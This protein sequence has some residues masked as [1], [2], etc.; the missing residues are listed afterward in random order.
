MYEKY[1]MYI[2]P[3]LNSFPVD[4]SDFLKLPWEKID[5]PSPVDIFVSIHGCGF[6]SSNIRR[7]DSSLRK[8]TV[9]RLL[10]E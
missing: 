8:A 3:L 4:P 9:L 7:D 10:K 6:F 5:F 2:P 1:T